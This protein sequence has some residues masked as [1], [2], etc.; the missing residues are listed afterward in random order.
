MSWA[1][2]IVET[3]ASDAGFATIVQPAASAGATF[4]LSSR[5]G[6]FQGLI[7]PTTPTGS[8]SWRTVKFGFAVGSDLA[9]DP[10][11]GARE[12]LVVVGEGR[13]LAR[14]LPQEL[15]V[16]ADLELGQTRAVLDEQLRQPAQELRALLGAAPSPWP[17]VEGAPR[18]RDRPVHVRGPRQRELGP[19]LARVGILR[20]ERL[21]ALGRGPAP[22]DVHLEG[23][24]ASLAK[25]GH[26]VPPQ[27][28]AI[29]SY[30]TAAPDRMSA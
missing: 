24:D 10:L 29:L 19:R 4:Q 23:A 6:E 14:H 3:G 2:P 11:G 13:H 16:V 5:S 25:C 21:A 28:F 18:R 9:A 12:P 26:R 7:A 30:T 20:T 22:I 15:A 27:T 8:W 1:R 17:L